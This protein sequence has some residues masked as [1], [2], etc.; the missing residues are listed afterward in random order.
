M[1]N[2]F[3]FDSFLKL[4]D[5]KDQNISVSQTKKPLPVQTPAHK[6]NEI[7]KMIGEE[8]IQNL[9]TVID[10]VQFKTYFEHTLSVTS[11][12]SES[13]ELMVSTP[14]IKKIIE[15]QY[16]KT[17]EDVLSNMLGKTLD[18]KV[19]SLN[20]S[21]SITQPVEAVHSKKTSVK[22]NTFTVSGLDN[23]APSIE[24]SAPTKSPIRGFL[25]THKTFDTFI[26]GPSNNL[27]FAAA[28]AIA[29]NPGQ[30]YP[31]V[32]IYG[33]SGLGKTHLIHSIANQLLVDQN[34]RTIEIIS[35]HTFIQK[36]V[37]AIQ[38]GQIDLFKK[39]YDEV[40]VLIIDDIHE[41]KDKG[42]TQEHFF[43]ILNDLTNRKKQLVFTSD[44]TPREISGLE[45]RLRSRLSSALVVEINQ[46]D[47][48]TRIAILRAK[49]LESDFFIT[50]DVVNLIAKCI[51]NNV[52]ELE[53]SLITLGVYSSIN[54]I[55]IDVE[56]A[57]EILKLSEE[58][59][60]HKTVTAESISRIVANY[61]R[62]PLNDLK[63][64]GKTKDV[65]FARQVA[66]YLI[67]QHQ[68]KTL[69]D[70]ALFFNKKDHTTV[71]YGIKVIKEKMKSDTVFAQEIVEIESL[72]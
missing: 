13:I 60:H 29:K 43:H 54:N 52:R 57:K 49:A 58:V 3:L 47:F 69:N 32:Y 25:D 15:N 44:K 23:V 34:K 11:L 22:N 62:V 65:S 27:A 19:H 53:G 55:E 31:S 7:N 46:P 70:I 24:V 71:M 56:L 48:E 2:H 40:D 8:L 64:K 4:D 26:V 61:Y 39:S 30:H 68:K 35:C 41:L 72:I 20:T 17:I 21:K 1:T 66:M 38:K 45:E 14:F 16:L 5:E 18:I 51:K 67:Y 50:D 63:G 36:F 42:G 28:K 10:P 33:K 59:E 9:K 6:D 12:G 37:E